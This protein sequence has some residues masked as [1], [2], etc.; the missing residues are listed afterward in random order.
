MLSYFTGSEEDSE[1]IVEKRVRVLRLHVETLTRQAEVREAELAAAKV[2][3][4]GFEAH[5][6]DAAPR[7]KKLFNR[8]EKLQAELKLA[9]EHHAAE[10]SRAADLAAHIFHG[11]KI[12]IYS[13]SK[14]KPCFLGCV[15][16][17]HCTFAGKN[18]PNIS[19]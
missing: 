8:L 13:L 3:L 4:K 1:D 5:Q 9:R 11:I 18:H 10:E 19:E 14:I 12:S 16:S 7:E 2:K 15:A 17:E 6:S